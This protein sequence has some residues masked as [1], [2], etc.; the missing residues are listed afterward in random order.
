VRELQRKLEVHHA[1]VMKAYRMV[2]KLFNQLRVA[3]IC[4]GAP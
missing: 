2:P 4:G 1:A 3:G